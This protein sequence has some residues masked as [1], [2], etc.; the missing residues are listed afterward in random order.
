MHD[1][2]AEKP[3]SYNGIAGFLHWLIV[4]LP[5]VQ[6]TVAWTI[7]DIGRDTKPVDPIAWHLSI[8]TFILLAMLVRPGWRAVSA[9]PPVP[10]RRANRL[11]R[12]RQRSLNEAS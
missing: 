10:A 2:R 9:V 7:P 5:V 3:G 1:R 6:F 11:R 4:V 8:G 12:H